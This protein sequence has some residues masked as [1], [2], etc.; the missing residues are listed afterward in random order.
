L[1]KIVLLR[2]GESAWNE[3]KRFTGWIDVPLLKKG[4]EEAH[5]AGKILKTE[6]FFSIPP[7]HPCSKEQ[8]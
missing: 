8:L 3:E 7:L 4:T 1:K 6:G 5:R 2:H